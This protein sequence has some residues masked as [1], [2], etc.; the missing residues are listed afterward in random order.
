MPTNSRPLS[1]RHYIFFCLM[2]ICG[3]GLRTIFPADMEWKADEKLMHYF[4]TQASERGEWPLVGMTNSKKMHN[5]GLSVWVFIA[6]SKIFGTSPLDLVRFVQ[7]SNIL[8]LLIIFG[9]AFTCKPRER[10]IW[11]WTAALLAVNPTAIILAR[12]IWAQSILPLFVIVFLCGQWRRHTTIGSF[13]FGI[14]GATIGQVHMA[15][16]F[17]AFTSYVGVIFFQREKWKVFPWILG[18]MIGALGLIPWIIKLQSFHPNGPS[19]IQLKYLFQFKFFRYF[20]ERSSGFGLKDN[21]G[22]HFVD[23]LKYPMIKGYSSYLGGLLVGLSVVTSLFVAVLCLRWVY[24][25]VKGKY[26]RKIPLKESYQEF[27]LTG[28][29]MTGILFSI[30]CISFQESYL[31]VIYPL[32]FMVIVWRIMNHRWH[33]RILVMIIGTQCLLS[34]LFLSFVHENEGLPRGDYGASYE[35]KILMSY[36]TRKWCMISLRFYNTALSC[37]KIEQ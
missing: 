9:V 22:D 35:R 4:T 15:G 25:A 32:S 12:K 26:W 18:N 20:I 1:P 27:M 30:F 7:W 34:V 29:L 3:I 16:F 8:A 37:G 14:V 28:V 24:S 33:R 31:L 21:M 5:P 6:G 19:S 13:I 17:L 2:I 10:E 36:E 23:F 11:L